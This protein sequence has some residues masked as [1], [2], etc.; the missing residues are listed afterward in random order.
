MKKI[1]KV[2]KRAELLKLPS[3]DWQKVSTYDHLYIVPTGK[4]HDSGYSL[5]AIIGVLCRDKDGERGEIAAHCDDINWSFPLKHPYDREGK[6]SNMLRTDCLFPSGIFRI[7]ASGEHYFTGKFKVGCSLSSTDVE[8][9]V[10][11]V[12][13][14][15]NKMTGTVIPMP[16]E[17]PT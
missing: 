13:D 11:P 1:A 4:K 10:Y 5:I 17:M 12:G 6:H 15:R 7:W 16:A 9:V 3:R 8:L 14:G 2:V